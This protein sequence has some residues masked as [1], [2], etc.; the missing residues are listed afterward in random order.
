[1]CSYPAPW[2][3]VRYSTPGVP[4]ARSYQLSAQLTRDAGFSIT[5]HLCLLGTIMPSKFRTKRVVFTLNNYSEKEACGLCE[6]VEAYEH[7][8]YA[9]CGKESGVGGT[10]HLQGAIFLGKTFPTARG[11]WKFWKGVPGLLRAH[12]EIPK[13]NQI[14]NDVYCAKEGNVLFRVG[15]PK[16]K[17]EDRLLAAMHQPSFREAVLSAP[18]LAAKSFNSF[19]AVYSIFNRATLHSPI[20]NLRGWQAK[21]IRLI[22]CQSNRQILFVVDTKGGAGKSFLVRHL[23]ATEDAFLCQ[24]GKGADIAY[25]ISKSD[26]MPSLFLFDMARSNSQDWFPWNLIENLK[27]QCFTSTKYESKLVILPT[28]AKVAVFMNEEPDRNKLTADRYCVLRVTSPSQKEIDAEKKP[29]SDATEST[30]DENSLSEDEKDAPT[31]TADQTTPKSERAHSV[32]WRVTK[33]RLGEHE[34]VSPKRA[35]RI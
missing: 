6:W 18:D 32:I 5:Q 8:E 17:S 24:G 27:N 31:D 1:M 7:V 30:N 14:Q 15:N 35:L 33:K 11:N 25:A 16:T 28:P 19:S 26:P 21:A 2:C 12:L 23:V 3:C 9:I 34:S 20:E 4:G 29:P 22:D 10:P 13:G